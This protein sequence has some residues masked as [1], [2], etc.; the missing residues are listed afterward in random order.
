MIEPQRSTGVGHSPTSICDELPMPIPEPT[1]TEASAA[2]TASC[3]TR[4]PQDGPDQVRLSRAIDGS[5]VTLIEH[6]PHWR[7]ASAPWSDMNI[8][9]IRWDDATATWSLDWADRNGGWLEL[10]DIPP[11]GT[12]QIAL[13]II[14]D[15]PHGCFWG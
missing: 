5:A 1:R 15:N 13:E 2:M 8:A 9:R 12:I 10:E 4:I 14:D 6:R 11:V 7:D 3:A